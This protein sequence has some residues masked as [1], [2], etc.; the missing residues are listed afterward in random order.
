MDGLHPILINGK[1]AGMWASVQARVG[2]LQCLIVRQPSRTP[3]TLL[4]FSKYRSPKGLLVILWE[5]RVARVWCQWVTWMRQHSG[6]EKRI[7][8]TRMWIGLCF[9]LAWG[10]EIRPSPPYLVAQAQLPM[11]SIESLY[12]EYSSSGLDIPFS[13]SA[14]HRA[15]TSTFKGLDLILWAGKLQSH[16]LKISAALNRKLSEWA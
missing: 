15:W 10:P 13:M 14:I 2:C 16:L 11:F 7:Q 12:S 8:L 5:Y 3:G 1:K 4:T 9:H 6:N